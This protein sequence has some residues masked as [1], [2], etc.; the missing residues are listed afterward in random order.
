MATLH[1][2]RRH[3][4]LALSATVASLG[5]AAC[6]SSSPAPAKP[7]DTKPA[8]QSTTA[9]A[10]SADAKP[11]AQAPV[12]AGKPVT[13]IGMVV[14]S[15]SRLWEEKLVPEFNKKHPSISVKLDPVPYGDMLAKQM[16]ELTRKPLAYD[17][18][19]TDDP[20]LPQLA[21]TGLLSPLK[22]TFKDITP[23]EYDWDDIHPAPLAAGEWKN[24]VFGVPV[25]SNLLLMF[26][27]RAVFQKAGVQP[28][29]D[30][31]TWADF[32]KAAE[33]L[34]KDTNGD[35]RADQWGFTTY[36]NREQLTPTIWQTIMNSNGGA[37]FDDAYRPTFNA[38]AG[39]AALDAHVRY[40]K[41]GPPGTESHSFTHI[42]EAFRQGQVGMIF[43][44][45]SAYRALA[46]DAQNT[47]LK[48]GDGGIAVMPAGSL[49]RSSHRGIWI[50]TVPKDAPNREAAWQWLAFIT[51][52]EGETF[53]AA[54]IGTFPARK[55]TLTSNPA[56][57]WLKDVYA[58]IFAGYDAIAKGK[59]WRPRMPDSDGVQQILARHHSRAV[60]KEA[61]PKAALDDAAKE[62]EAFLKDKGYYK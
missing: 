24:T 9:P 25:R 31:F 50:G 19:I 26:F 12:A 21:D 52:K 37:L 18:L 2:T 60:T 46:V 22:E 42:N 17:F 48:P 11:A 41:Y 39:V 36:Y 54:N 40:A 14:D 53:S 32:E 15:Y 45:G 5:L 62:V 16:L 23:P 28:P 51:S 55:S 13:I 34:V 49:G 58:A 4:L 3:V 57:A 6:S 38:E 29:G 33:A 56:E 8:A 27:N 44:W 47:T 10:K 20:W 30:T 59:M 61:T 7:A 43:N 35:G 1:P